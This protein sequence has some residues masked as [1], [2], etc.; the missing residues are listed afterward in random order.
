MKVHT[1]KQ[2]SDSWWAARRGRPSASRFGDILQPVKMQLGK[3]AE[4][5]ACELIGDLLDMNYGPKDEFATSAMRSG[6]VMEPHI[7]RYYE[8]QRDIEVQ[9]VGLC[10]SDDGRFTGSPDGLCADDGVLELKHPTP[11]VQIKYLLDGGV[12]AE[13]LGQVHGHLIVTGRKWVDFLSYVPGLPEL[14]IRVEP[15]GYTEKLAIALDEFWDL[16]TNMKAQIIGQPDAVRDHA[17]AGA[18]YVS[19]F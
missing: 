11:K 14:L 19:P 15:D 18:N 5:Y 2:Y 7:R 10:E 17:I 6:T 12:P 4:S 8:F 13:Y 3:G 9:E 1:F 16:F